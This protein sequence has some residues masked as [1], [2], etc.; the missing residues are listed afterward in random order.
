[1]A[2]CINRTNL[3]VYHKRLDGGNGLDN[4]EVLCPR[5][6]EKTRASGRNGVNAGAPS[7][8]LQIKQAA[9]RRAV[10]R[11]ECERQICGTH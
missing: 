3:E 2:R 5:C 11:C 1:M 6:H 8:S 10:N 7:F 9:L 4:A